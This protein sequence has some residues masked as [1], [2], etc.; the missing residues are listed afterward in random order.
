MGEKIRIGREL[1]QKQAHR[2]RG[3]ELPA[4]Y[5]RTRECKLS[6]LSV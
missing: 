6:L 1:A 2:Y 5:N 3:C 4:W